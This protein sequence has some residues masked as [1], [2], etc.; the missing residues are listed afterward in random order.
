MLEGHE[1]FLLAPCLLLLFKDDF[2]QFAELTLRVVLLILQF[3]VLLVSYGQLSLQLAHLRFDLLFFLGY[4]HDFLHNIVRVRFV[5]LEQLLLLYQLLIELLNL[6]TALLFLLVHFL[7][8]QLILLLQ[9]LN[10]LSLFALNEYFNLFFHLLD[11][12]LEKGILIGLL[13]LA[14]TQL[15]AG[16]FQ[17]LCLLF[18]LFCVL[19]L[20]Q[21]GFLE[22]ELHLL[23]DV[24]QLRH[25]LLQLLV[26][27]CL[28]LHGHFHV[29][30]HGLE[31]EGLLRFLGEELLKLANFALFGL[32]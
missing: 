28:L 31:S 3:L 30:E 17:A 26:V 11:L 1:Q 29:V 8:M 10:V 18:G 23:I 16:L 19:G 24:L 22:L 15:S 9:F 6:R 12:V 4:L 27:L 13:R 25:L 21:L 14:L 5:H 7:Q 20:F 2:L 32:L